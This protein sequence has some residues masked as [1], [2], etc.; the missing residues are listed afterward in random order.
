[1]HFFHY[2]ILLGFHDDCEN[3]TFGYYKKMVYMPQSNFLF[4]FLSEVVCE[5]SPQSSGYLISVKSEGSS[6]KR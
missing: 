3:N 6:E 2:N 4:D 1:M 5:A